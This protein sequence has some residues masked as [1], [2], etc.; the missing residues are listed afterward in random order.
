VKCQICGRQNEEHAEYCGECGHRPNPKF[1]SEFLQITLLAHHLR[2]QER[3]VPAPATLGRGRPTL[4]GEP[5]RYDDAGRLACVS[6]PAMSGTN[7]VTITF[8]VAECP[9]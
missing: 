4:Y 8:P 5:V 9:P 6:V 3:F 1:E 2:A 7:P